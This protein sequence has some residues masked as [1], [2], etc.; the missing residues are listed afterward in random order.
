MRKRVWFLCGF[1]VVFVWFATLLVDR[2]D[3]PQKK[4]SEK[5]FL[6][7]VNSDFKGTVFVNF[8]LKSAD[9]A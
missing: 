5:L 2:A 7:C 1:C 8:L 6:S 9:T 3:E 4:L